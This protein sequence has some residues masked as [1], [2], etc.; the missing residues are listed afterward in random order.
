MPGFGGLSDSPLPSTSH[1]FRDGTTIASP[2]P[3]HVSPSPRR[4]TD[5]TEIPA[6]RMSAGDRTKN[7]RD[8]RELRELVLPTPAY[9]PSSPPDVPTY[10]SVS[11]LRRARW[12]KNPADVVE[13]RERSM[14]DCCIR[15]VTPDPNRIGLAEG[16]YSDS[17][18]DGSLP[19][20]NGESSFG[21]WSRC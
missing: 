10:A 8:L 4:A 11:P 20:D 3:A 19:S 6:R 9:M 2:Q 17:G 16:D 15:R 7:D 5:A 21:R 12:T 14:S 1:D 18:D 13:H